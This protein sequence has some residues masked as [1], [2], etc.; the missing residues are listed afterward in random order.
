MGK[1]LSGFIKGFV[2]GW[3]LIPS[4]NDRE[5]QAAKTRALNAGATL[6]EEKAKKAAAGT[7]GAKDQAYIDNLTDLKRIRQERLDFDRGK[8][9]AVP[10]AEAAK[11]PAATDDEIEQQMEG[12][13]EL[14]K[15]GVMPKVRRYANGGGVVE[16][17][18]A[19]HQEWMAQATTT[20]AIPVAS[21]PPQAATPTPQSEMNAGPGFS[22]AAALD[23]AEVGMNGLVEKYGLD[24]DEAVDTPEGDKR[25]RDFSEAKGGGDATQLRQIDEKIGSSPQLSESQLVL[26]RGAAI[27]EIYRAKGQGARAKEALTELTEIHKGVHNQYKA[28]SQAAAKGG[29]LDE[30]IKF[31]IKAYS[32]VPDGYDIQLQ[33]APD[34]RFALKL[35]DETTG[36]VIDRALKTPDEMLQIVTKFN[37]NSY[38]DLVSAAAGK[39]YEELNKTKADAKA[40]DDGKTFAGAIGGEPRYQ[41]MK[42][43]SIVAAEG[44]NRARQGDV[45]KADD[46]N[47]DRLDTGVSEGR[48][49][50]ETA[51]EPT[52]T[53]EFADLPIGAWFINPKDKVV[54]QKVKPKAA[55]QPAAAQ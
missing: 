28:I 32:Y 5:Y 42:Q 8:P 31:G 38:E 10:A 37:M 47:K 15:G 22:Y 35:T 45:T 7:L 21:A 4:K 46:A 3:E 13:P 54:M 20:P 6:D 12:I 23:A 44:I 24:K 51:T 43:D 19:G 14:A 1:A 33:K 53:Q 48:W 39:R 18:P 34:G 41:G 9:T 50:K 17:E 40:L 52:T 26:K 16:D 49:T 2:V 36:K 25:T 55:S 11:G 27:L 30:A 29:K